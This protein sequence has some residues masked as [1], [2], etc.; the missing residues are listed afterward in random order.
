MRRLFLIVLIALL[1]LR[2]WAGAVMSVEMALQSRV[3]AHHTVSVTGLES[4]LAPG[5]AVKKS[6]CHE[7][8]AISG[9][10]GTSDSRDTPPSSQC[11]TCVACQICH[12]VAL[13]GMPPIAIAP[14]AFSSPQPVGGIRFASATLAAYLKPPIS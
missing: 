9:D 7:Q 5:A 8:M 1:P 3:A 13:T 10:S 12:T 4:A 2:G 6:D 11:S 14:P